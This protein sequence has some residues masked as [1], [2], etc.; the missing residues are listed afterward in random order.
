MH[1]NYFWVCYLAFMFLFGINAYSQENEKQSQWHWGVYSDITPYLDTDL[2]QFPFIRKSVEKYNDFNN[3]INGSFYSWKVGFRIEHPMMH[4]KLAFYS[5]LHY[6]NLN[7]GMEYDDYGSSEFMLVNVSP[8]NQDIHFIRT[9]S[10]NQKCHYVGVQFGVKGN[11]Y[12]G[13]VTQLYVNANVDCNFLL[14]HH[15]DIDFYNP[16][17]ATYSNE[18]KSLFNSPSKIYSAVNLTG[19]LKF[20]EISGVNLAIETGPS[21]LL[22]NKM[23]SITKATV[24]FVFQTCFYLPF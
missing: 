3:Y 20:G 8:D 18:I 7:S 19:G 15:M 6:S 10:F 12:S 21:I 13:T 24:G 11:L 22:T 9:T 2:N 17:M 5:G 4:D 23:S 1:T 14:N 16:S